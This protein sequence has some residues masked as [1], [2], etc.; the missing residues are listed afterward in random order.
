MRALGEALV[1]DLVF[2]PLGV[3]GW[4]AVDVALGLAVLGL[5]QL[6]GRTR[7]RDAGDA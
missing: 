7:P 6:R 2:G 5:L 1:V 4:F 3:L